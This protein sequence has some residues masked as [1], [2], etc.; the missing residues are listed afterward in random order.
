M[1]TSTS[2]AVYNQ[3]Y[4]SRPL[5][6]G[7]TASRATAHT[8]FWLHRG[9]KVKQKR[10]QSKAD[11]SMSSPL[12]RGGHAFGVEPVFLYPPSTSLE[13]SSLPGV[14]LSLTIRWHLPQ[15]P[16]LGPM[17][18]LLVLNEPFLTSLKPWLPQGN[19]PA[20]FN[21]HHDWVVKPHV[22]ES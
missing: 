8:F 19:G 15:V 13:H 2:P 3:L 10:K 17:C 7:P 18:A 5:L 14:V 22:P 21:I 11:L 9:I 16:S 6:W 1:E 4:I 12:P 20:Q